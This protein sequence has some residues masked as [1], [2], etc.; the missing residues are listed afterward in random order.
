MCPYRCT[1]HCNECR[2]S[3]GGE[4]KKGKET[5]RNIGDKI[6]TP[7]PTLCVCMCVPKHV[8][9]LTP[10]TCSTPTTPCHPLALVPCMACDTPDK[11]EKTKQPAMKTMRVQAT[12]STSE[13][14][15]QCLHSSAPGPCHH[16]PGG[17][18]K[19]GFVRIAAAASLNEGLMEG[20]DF[21]WPL[22]CLVFM[23]RFRAL[24]SK[25]RGRYGL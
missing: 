18:L 19:H 3:W 6:K 13:R 7:R 1:L 4:N 20:I 10:P 22:R 2:C 12:D 23:T 16:I 24:R 14:A 9:S 21:L 17:Y 15:V 8:C 5:P 25:D 11:N